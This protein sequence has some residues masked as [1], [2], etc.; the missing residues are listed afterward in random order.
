[1]CVQVRST[2]RRTRKKE[3]RVGFSQQQRSLRLTLGESHVTDKAVG[4][5][6]RARNTRLPWT[7]RSR[8][9]APRANPQVS[10]AVTAM[11]IRDGATRGATRRPAPLRAA[12]ARHQPELVTARN[13]FEYSY[14]LD[15]CCSRSGRDYVFTFANTV[16]SFYCGRLWTMQISFSKTNYRCAL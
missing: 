5:Q 10:S 13:K 2:A 14:I 12:T 7:R 9:P 3:S 4:R 11:K 15:F 16:M 6:K 1:M 8:S